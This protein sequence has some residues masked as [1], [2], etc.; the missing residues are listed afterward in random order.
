MV[1]LYSAS[2]INDLAQGRVPSRFALDIFESRVKCRI[3]VRF[4]LQYVQCFRFERS[5]L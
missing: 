5:G 3:K 2:S 1:S 4:V